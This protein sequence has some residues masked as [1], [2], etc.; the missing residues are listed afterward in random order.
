M[1]TRKVNLNWLIALALLHQR[2]SFLSGLCFSL[3]A[4]YAAARLKHYV[5]LKDSSA[6]QR[7]A[8]LRPFRPRFF[9]CPSCL[10]SSF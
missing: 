3:A 8:V 5:E 6:A 1:A 7:E 4:A 9:A 2:Q 10:A